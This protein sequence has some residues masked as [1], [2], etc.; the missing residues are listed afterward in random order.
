MECSALGHQCGHFADVDFSGRVDWPGQHRIEVTT[1][2]VRLVFQRLVCRVAKDGPNAPKV[3]TQHFNVIEVP[4]TLLCPVSAQEEDV[5]V[6]FRSPSAFYLRYE[7][8]RI[9]GIDAPHQTEFGRSLARPNESWMYNSCT[10]SLNHPTCVWLL[11]DDALLRLGDDSGLRIY[12]KR[13]AAAG[14]WTSIVSCR[15]EELAP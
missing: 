2:A 9:I 15:A 13:A 4:L 10:F 6:L 14:Q 12:L 8:P 11:L 5:P 7:R 3:V 1:Y